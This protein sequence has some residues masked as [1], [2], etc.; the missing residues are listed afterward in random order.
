MTRQSRRS[1]KVCLWHENMLGHIIF[2]Q[3]DSKR[4]ITHR[5]SIP[6]NSCDNHSN[7]SELR[8]WTSLVQ[9][10]VLLVQ[11]THSTQQRSWTRMVQ[12]HPKRSD[13]EWMEL[14]QECRTSGLTDKAWCE[15]NHIQR[16]S[17]YYHIR[18]FRNMACEIPDNPVSSCQEQHE[19]WSAILTL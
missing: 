4:W 14:I 15:R 13:Q 5:L 11:Y 3:I 12:R 1:W 2:L 9:S 16:S 10:E 18:R 8:H 19:V 6:A 17:L 7:P